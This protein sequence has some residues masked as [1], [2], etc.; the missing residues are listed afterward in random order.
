MIDCIWN[1][2][3]THTIVILLLKFTVDT[4]SQQKITR[5]QSLLVKQETKKQ[6]ICT[7]ATS[8]RIC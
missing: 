6:I 1:S 3:L 2:K 8:K 7:S 5:R 4:L